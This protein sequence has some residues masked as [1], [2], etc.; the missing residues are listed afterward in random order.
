[1]LPNQTK[2]LERL[3][4]L[5]RMLD[6]AT[7]EIAIL[8]EKAIRA[9]AQYEVAYAKSFLSSEG[10]MDLRKHHSTITCAD[11]KLELE[12]AEAKVRAVKERINTLRSQISIGQSL[13]AAI[14]QQ[15]MGEGLGQHI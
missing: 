3:A 11:L 6:N 1:M 5:S 14:R 13:S 10:A 9:K 15:F 4:E 7:D 2:T 8:D 12:L